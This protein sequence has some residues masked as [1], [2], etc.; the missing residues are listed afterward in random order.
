MAKGKSPKNREAKKPK[1]D[2]SKD[3]TNARTPANK[4]GISIGHKK[5][6]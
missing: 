1:K 6:N 3:K 5:V 2:K 4:A